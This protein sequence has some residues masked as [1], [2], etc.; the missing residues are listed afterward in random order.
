MIPLS[1]AAYQYAFPAIPPVIV[2]TCMGILCLAVVLRE[3]AS[4]VSISFWAL[5]ASVSIWLLSFGGIYASRDL[6]GALAWSRIEHLGVAFIPCA[7]YSF[8][9]N[10]TQPRGQWKRTVHATLLISALFSIAGLTS[11]HFVIG[12]KNYAWGPYPQYGWLGGLFLVYFAIFYGSGLTLFWKAYRRLE[13]GPAQT[14]LR[15]LFLAFFFSL[16]GAVDFLPCF[17]FTVYPVGYLPVYA[18]VL[19]LAQVI[20]QFGFP[21]IT[22]A[23]AA[24]EIIETMPSALF[25][26]DQDGVIRVA[27]REACSLFGHPESE[28]LGCPISGALEGF[29][30]ARQQQTLME[31]GAPQQ[32]ET[33]IH[34]PEQGARLC[35]VSIS[36]VRDDRQRP[37]AYVCVAKDITEERRAQAALQVSEQRLRRLVDSNMIGFMLVDASGKILEANEAFLD[38][39]GYTQE[40]LSSGTFGGPSLTPEE[41]RSTD[42]WMEQRL[43]ADGM[44]PPVEMEYIRKDGRRVPVLV[45]VVRLDEISNHNLCFIVDASERRAAVQAL[46]KAYDTL[47]IKVRERTKELEQ[48][49][50]RR[51]R[52]E[53]AL[54]HLAIR[55]ALT[56]LYNRRG[57]L[58]LGN[59]FRERAQRRNKPLWVVMADLDGLKPIN[60]TFGHTE[61]DFAIVQSAGL[62]KSVLRESDLLARIGGDEFAAIIMDDSC[63][64]E[65]LKKRLDTKFDDYNRYSGRPYKLALS[66]GAVQIDPSDSGSLESL[67]GRA[68]KDLYRTK[69][70]R[71][72]PRLRPT[73][74]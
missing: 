28:L 31:T 64:I 35:S 56:N 40:D 19:L 60:D 26:L 57:F 72:A 59:Q 21:D 12:L 33:I 41:Y 36:L 13:A 34:S 23:F 54:R 42:E 1:L 43:R 38:L 10:V 32:Y 14:R 24:N 20:W 46:Q 50:E 27:N 18:G 6:A 58:D 68:D 63:D 16:L 61:G 62:L 37:V 2:G 4:Q 55:D 67:I 7:L 52:A 51:E 11:N 47:E 44:C 73:A 39:L 71:K 65:D 9:V 69:R 70:H 29:F 30:T 3:R 66:V 49:I 17:G 74:S 48:E 15:T 53:E 22:P 5:T 45:G 25:V 8:A